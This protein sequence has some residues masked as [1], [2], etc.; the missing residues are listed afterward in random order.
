LGS[1]GPSAGAIHC[2]FPRGPIA[3]IEQRQRL[4][5][6]FVSAVVEPFVA[7]EQGHKPADPIVGAFGCGLIS[8][9]DRRG[10]LDQLVNAPHKEFGV[11]HVALLCS[12]GAMVA[13]IFEKVFIVKRLTPI[14]SSEV[15]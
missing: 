6:H 9:L 8:F 15:L 13:D 5:E 1:L 7:T 4:V 3:S 14:S 10:F 11:C 12:S 2:A